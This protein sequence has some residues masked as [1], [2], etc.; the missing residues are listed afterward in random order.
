MDYSTPGF[1]VPHYILKFVQVHVHW[2]G[3]AIQ[4][5]HLLPPSFFTF[6]FS[7]H[8]DLFQWGNCLH[9]VSKYWSISFSISPSNE[10]I[11]SGFI[12][13][14]IYLFDL[15]A[16][17]VTLKSLHQQ[18]NSKALVLQ[19]S[20]IFMV[21][22]SNPYM[23]IGKTVALTDFIGKVMSLLFNTLSRFV[24]DIF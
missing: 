11:G 14:R 12:F 2:V 19:C 15:L 9:Q 13:F 1:P 6:N 24:I 10:F 4:S 8:H 23:T 17:Q 18:Q 22:I 5:T 21:Q 20:D 7:Q 16:V 3:D